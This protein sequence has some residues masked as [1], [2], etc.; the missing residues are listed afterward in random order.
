[1]GGL[2]KGVPIYSPPSPELG[3][4]IITLSKGRKLAISPKKMFYLFEL[5][6]KIFFL[7]ILVKKNVSFFSLLVNNFTVSKQF[8]E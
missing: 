6:G 1:M 2:G 3:G 4:T 7:V 8:G 5:L